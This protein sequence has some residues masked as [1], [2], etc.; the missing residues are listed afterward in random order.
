MN[1]RVLLYLLVAIQIVYLVSC[2]SPG[3]KKRK[4]PV[5]E[6]STLS[7]LL[8]QGKLSPKSQAYLKKLGLHTGFRKNPEGLVAALSKQLA[9]EYSTEGLIALIEICS[10]TADR[11][12]R[13]EPSQ[14]VAYHLTAAEAAFKVGFGKS[15]DSD[16]FVKSYNDSTEEVVRIL[17]DPEEPWNEDAVFKGPVQSYHIRLRKRGDGIIDPSFYDDIYPANHLEFEDISFGRHVSDG[18]GG[19]LVGHRNGTAERRIKNPYLATVGMSL[20]VNAT[21]DFSRGGGDVE[22]AFHDLMIND[23]IRLQG[24]KLPLSADRTAPFAIFY[25][26]A[27][28]HNVGWDGDRKSVV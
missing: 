28:K 5:G 16:K 7:A 17:F 19:A 2:A 14:A 11:L 23:S 27:P 13:R 24:R 10:I 9:T 20:P 18:V 3:V 15:P 1:S 12:E 4:R 6:A 8:E 22:L 25:N 26:Y 21:L